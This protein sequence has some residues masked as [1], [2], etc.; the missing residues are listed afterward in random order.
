MCSNTAPAFGGL[1]CSGASQEANTCRL[2]R[3]PDWSPW[4][5]G[6]CS[7]TCGNGTETRVRHCSTGHTKDCTGSSSEVV[8]CQMAPCG[9]NGSWSLWSTW[10]QC[11]VTCEDGHIQRTRTCTNPAPAFA[12][13]N[14]SGESLETSACKLAKCPKGTDAFNEP[15][16]FREA[17][18][19]GFHEVTNFGFREATGFGFLEP[20]NFVKLL[21]SNVLKSTLQETGP[22]QPGPHR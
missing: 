12:C 14:C 13:L 19:F 17:T 20:I 8:G 10:S 1:N 22:L 15:S 5:N 2:A 11:D 18:G 4:F 21:T 16:G 6:K 3:C 9:V 7:G